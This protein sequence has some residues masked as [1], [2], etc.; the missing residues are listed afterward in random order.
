MK[1]FLEFNDAGASDST[2]VT[3]TMKDIRA[4]LD[5]EKSLLLGLTKG[6][7]LLSQVRSQLSEQQSET[8]RLEEV[9]VT[10]ARS[11]TLMQRQYKESAE[12]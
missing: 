6:Q 12:L 3:V 10:Q 8:I 11:M 9:V 7:I 2:P 1:T 5:A 4:W